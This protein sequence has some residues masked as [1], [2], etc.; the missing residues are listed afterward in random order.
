[1][2]ALL[3]IG[4]LLVVAGGVMLLVEMFRTS[5]WW[6]LLCLLIP[7]LQF[8][9]VIVHWQQAWRP[10]L[11][12]TLGFLL[13]LAAVFA[14]GNSDVQ[15]QEFR[16][17]ATYY[18]HSNAPAPVT[19]TVTVAASADEKKNDVVESNTGKP[20]P[21]AATQA[22]PEGERAVYKCKDAQGKTSYSDQPCTGKMAVLSVKAEYDGPPVAD[23]VEAVQTV[24]KS[25]SGAVESITSAKPEAAE[26]PAKGA[27][28]DGRTRCSEMTSCAEAMY[29]LQHCPGT[30]MDGNGDGVPCEEQWC[31]TRF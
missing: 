19:E 3:I 29:F 9:F 27:R 11:V 13:V 23:P 12:Q 26:K 28:C 31:G 17:K 25:V 22:P 20:A 24:T 16:S 8:V 4:L 5:V 10:L 14:G 6:G 30:K 18:W 7:P 2:T 1:M 15:F 21:V